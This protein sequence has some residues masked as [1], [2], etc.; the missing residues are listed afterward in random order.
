MAS[1]S[2]A[3]VM[4]D[5]DASEVIV[6]AKMM[7]MVKNMI[8]MLITLRGEKR[9]EVMMA[10]MVMVIVVMGISKNLEQD[11]LH[12]AGR[13]NY[14]KSFITNLAKSFYSAY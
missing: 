14:S 9:L 13:P 10:K 8:M 1:I 2:L 12:I 11:S 3:A 7:V 6:M 4:K 5:G